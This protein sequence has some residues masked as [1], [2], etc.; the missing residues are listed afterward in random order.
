MTQLAVP[1]PASAGGP[2]TDRYPSA[3]RLA[4]SGPAA[5]RARAA[6]ASFLADAGARVV[7]SGHHVTAAPD[8]RLLLRVV[9]RLPAFGYDLPALGRMF[10]AAVAGTYDMRYRLSD[11]AARPRIAVF[12]SRQDDCLLDLLRRWRH[13]ELPA[14]IGL[15]VSNHGDL[16]GQAAGFAVPYTHVPVTAGA[17]ASAEERQLEL[18]RG[19]FDLV[20]L[21]RY[22]QV[23][24]GDFL[25]RVGIPVIN[26]HHSLLP[27]FAGASPHR[28]ARQRGVKVVGAT[29]HYVTETLDAGP[30]I[31][32]D[33][34][35]VGPDDDLT[36]L[37]AGLARRVLA[38]AVRWHCEDRVFVHG[39]TTTV[40]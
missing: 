27:A 19:R 24:S 22:M 29:A 15:V 38:R 25:E 31:E 1:G 13:G 39:S 20:V 18:V 36:E 11:A 5:P 8:S 28:Q 23:L 35:R 40:L 12:A 6:V 32:Q 17:K 10:G 37:N 34:A 33:A 14:D 7:E 4:V 2:G 30:I 26:I 9:F 3:A 16:A 21:A